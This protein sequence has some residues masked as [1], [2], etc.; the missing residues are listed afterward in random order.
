M[1]ELTVKLKTARGKGY[2]TIL[3]QIL[4]ECGEKIVVDA[5]ELASQQ[6]GKL[7]VIDIATLANKYDLNYKATCEWLEECKVLPCGAYERLKDRGL[8]ARDVLIAANER[9]AARSESE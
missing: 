8:K 7:K 3:K 5:K 2:Y 1:R 6:G 9:A 4:S